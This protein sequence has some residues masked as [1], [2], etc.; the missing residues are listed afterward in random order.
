MAVPK[1]KV[2]RARRNTRRFASFNKLGKPTVTTDV[3]GN[4]TR[5]HSITREMLASGRYLESTAKYNKKQSS[6]KA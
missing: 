4:S 2:S 6:A 5:P 3:M 1:K